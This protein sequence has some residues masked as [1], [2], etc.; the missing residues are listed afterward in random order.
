MLMFNLFY[1]GKVNLPINV[2]QA[3]EGG[4]SCTYIDLCPLTP[5]DR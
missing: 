5:D 1:F 3:S 4:M 2:P